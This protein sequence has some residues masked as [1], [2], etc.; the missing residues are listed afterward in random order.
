MQLAWHIAEE[1]GSL[2][3]KGACTFCKNIDM[4]Y[5]F[6]F[7][8]TECILNKLVYPHIIARESCEIY[9]LVKIQYLEVYMID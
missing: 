3:L 4:V 6:D 1:N 5:N 7:I 2:W 9:C 8:Y